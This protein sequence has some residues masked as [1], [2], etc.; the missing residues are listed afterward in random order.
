MSPKSG[1][2]PLS[3]LFNIVLEVLGSTGE[4]MKSTQI[5]KKMKIYFIHK[6]PDHI[7]RKSNRSYKKTFRISEFNKVARY[8]IYIQNSIVFLYTNKEHLEIEKTFKY[9]FL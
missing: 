4:K 5:G 7:C 2:C 9:H 6:E 8:K 3:L 1:G